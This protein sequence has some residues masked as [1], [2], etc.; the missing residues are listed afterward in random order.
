MKVFLWGRAW[1]GSVIYRTTTAATPPTRNMLRTSSTTSR[2]KYSSSTSW[3]GEDHRIRLHCMTRG[4]TKFNNG[5]VP[6]AHFL[7]QFEEGREKVIWVRKITFYQHFD[8][9]LQL[10]SGRKWKKWETTL[11]FITMHYQGYTSLEVKGLSIYAAA[12]W[13]ATESWGRYKAMSSHWTVSHSSQTILSPLPTSSFWS[14]VGGKAWEE[15]PVVMCVW[16]CST[17][18]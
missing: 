5:L 7:I 4:T 16:L 8:W 11:L 17:A 6:R 12:N 15:V 2:P 3:N 13:E 18:Y 14:L 10:S 9:M 1:I